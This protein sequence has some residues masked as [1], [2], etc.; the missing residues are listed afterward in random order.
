[1]TPSQKTNADFSALLRARNTLY[2]VVTREEVRV[3]RAIIEAAGAAKFQTRFWD[4]ATGL[5][6]ETGGP[7]DPNMLNPFPVL[8]R[9]RNDKTRMLYV[10]RDIPAWFDPQ[11]VRMLRSLARSLPVAP[12]DEARAIVILTPRSE[13]PP[14]LAGHATVIDYPLPARP[15]IAEILDGALGSVR[16]DI[17]AAATPTNGAREAAI[18]AAVGLTA[19]EAANCYAKSLVTTKTIDPGQISS[20]KRRV[21]AREKVLTWYDPEPRGLDAVGGL[22]LLKEWLKARRSAFSEEDPARGRPRKREEPHGKG[23]RDRLGHAAPTLGPRR[24]PLEVRGRERGQH[25]KGARRR[26]DRGAVRALARRD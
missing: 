2:W 20:E 13:V 26:R 12:L 5:T 8:E 3:E 1:M 24:A 19:E 10:L 18:D 7:V 21:I 17:R 25:P 11:I 9:I 14:E 22:E 15:E 23:H 4:C 16:E 6:N